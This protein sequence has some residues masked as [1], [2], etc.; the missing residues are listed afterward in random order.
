MTIPRSPAELIT[1]EVEAR[2]RAI[3]DEFDSFSPPMQQHARMLVGLSLTDE[4]SDGTFRDLLAVTYLFW[5]ECNQAR[6]VA[7]HREP[8]EFQTVVR[9][10]QIDQFLNGAILALNSIPELLEDSYEVKDVELDGS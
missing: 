6:F 5:R 4:L 7:T 2:A 10:V 3:F 9:T 1:K 8:G